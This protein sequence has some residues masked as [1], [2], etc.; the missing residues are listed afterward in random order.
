MD[1]LTTSFVIILFLLLLLA[2][3]LWVALALMSVSLLTVL[4]FSS[5][6]AGSVLANTIWSHTTIWTLV[7]LPLFIWMGEILFRTKLAE[8]MF[9][10]IA[11]WVGRI[12]GRLLHVNIFGCAIFAAVSGSSAATAMTIGKM[13]I[14]ELSKRRYNENMVLGSLAGSA[15]LGLLIPPSI[16][17]IVYGVSADVSIVKLFIAGVV[18]GI[19]IALLFF[20]YVAVWGTMHPDGT[21]ADAEAPSWAEKLRSLPKLAPVILLI[22]A[23]MMSIYF[24]WATATEAAAL[25]VLGALLIAM[26]T[27]SLSAATFVDSLLGATKTT[28]MIGLILA[29]ASGF[30]VAMG[31]VGIPEALAVAIRDLN[32]SPYALLVVLTLFFV[33]LGCFLDGISVVVLSSAVILPMVQAAGIDLLWFGI[34]IVLVVEMSQVTPPVGFN[35]FVIQGLTGKSIFHVARATLPFFILMVVAV[36]IITVFPEIVTTLPRWAKGG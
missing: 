32:L 3:G 25:G 19:M 33:V 4:T 23:V 8:N 1:L 28:S 20:I 7:S 17:M 35:L 2:G 15:T 36:V 12:P 14:P 5:V 13:S 29:G 16:I 24:G 27:G 26:A 31:F 6:P 22:V 34:F 9:S 18:P 10:G 30:S 11:P 21:P